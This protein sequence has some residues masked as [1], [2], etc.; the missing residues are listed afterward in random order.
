MYPGQV[1]GYLRVSKEVSQI[2]RHLSESSKERAAI[3]SNKERLMESL[4][5]EDFYDVTDEDS[6]NKIEEVDGLEGVER[7]QLK[8]AMK[9]NREMDWRLAKGVEEVCEIRFLILF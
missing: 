8:Q 1:E 3:K 4:S 9:E 6:D 5:E 7:R 2:M